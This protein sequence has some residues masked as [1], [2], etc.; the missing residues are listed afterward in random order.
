MARKYIQ[1]KYKVKKP[2]K[3][4]GNPNDVFFRSSLELRFFN[5]LESNS[6]ILSWSSETTIIPYYSPVDKKMHRYFC[7]IRCKIKKSSGEI[8][9]YLVEIKPS[10]QLLPPKKPKKQ[11]KRYLEECVTYTI[12][13]AKFKAAEKYCLERNWQWLIITEKGL[14]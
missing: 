11:T 5:W 14:T 9:T 4:Q 7:D 3:Y 13:Q 6:S 10:T 2:E 8:E 1:G 12:N